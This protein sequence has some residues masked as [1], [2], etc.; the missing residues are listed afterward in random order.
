[1][2]AL[3]ALSSDEDEPSTPPSHMAI[4]QENYDNVEQKPKEGSTRQASLPP[5][6]V[7]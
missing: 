5:E 3:A 7:F 6:F 2:A 1:M 4:K